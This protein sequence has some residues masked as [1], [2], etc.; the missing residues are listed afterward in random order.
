MLPSDERALREGFFARSAP[1]RGLYGRRRIEFEVV[2]IAQPQGSSKSFGFHLKDHAGTPIIGRTG[3]PLI[4]TITTSDNPNLKAWRN[5]VASA[6]QRAIAAIDS[7]TLFTG[8]VA[9]DVV[10]NLPRPQSLPKKVT[11]HLKKPDA[12]KLLRSTEDALSGVLWR[13]DSQLTEIRVRKRYAEPN[14]P[15]RA[16]IAV[17]G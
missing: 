12:S 4:R 17:E 3:E 8:A 6:A 13:D 5:L 15:A 1:D 9:L 10:F 16:V 11:A 2:G 14:Q 7:F